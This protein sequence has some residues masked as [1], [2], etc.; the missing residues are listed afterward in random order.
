MT[1]EVAL[2]EGH[3]P[4][5]GLTGTRPDR[6]ERCRPAMPGGGFAAIVVHRQGAT[7]RP[8]GGGWWSTT[9]PDRPGAGTRGRPA[10]GQPGRSAVPPPAGSGW[11]PAPHDRCLLRRLNLRCPKVVFP[12]GGWHVRCLP[13]LVPGGCHGTDDSDADRGGRSRNDDGG[14]GD[15]RGGGGAHLPRIGE[16]TE[17]DLLDLS[18]I[19][20]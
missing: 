9:D 12:G 3:C 7:P 15:D 18:L 5:T 11:R 19:H 10:A 6:R 16:H 17:H 2:S 1:F 20:I 14:D 13:A 8:G 4:R